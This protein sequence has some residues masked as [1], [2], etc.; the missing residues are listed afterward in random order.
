MRL[1]SIFHLTLL[2]CLPVCMKVRARARSQTRSAEKHSTG[3]HCS[4]DQIKNLVFSLANIFVNNDDQWS[5]IIIIC[6]VEVNHDRWFSTVSS[7]FS[8]VRGFPNVRKCVNIITRPVGKT[9][10][11]ILLAGIFHCAR[12]KRRSTPTAAHLR[13]TWICTNWYRIHLNELSAC[14]TTGSGWFD[15]A[16]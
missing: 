16:R 8:S 1:P 12:A 5:Y 3:N 10:S 14:R 6:K 4:C 15:S 11:R 13:H 9:S 7:F 2:V